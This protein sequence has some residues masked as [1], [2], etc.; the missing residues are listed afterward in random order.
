MDGYC[1]YVATY[2][3]ILVEA[4]VEQI[5]DVASTFPPCLMHFLYRPSA[6]FCMSLEVLCCNTSRFRECGST[7]LDEWCRGEVRKRGVR[8]AQGCV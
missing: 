7:L 6:P 4:P 1:V 5:Q 8:V 3:K 2:L